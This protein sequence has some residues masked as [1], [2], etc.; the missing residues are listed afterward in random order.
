[1]VIH[2][3][4]AAAPGTA[5]RTAAVVFAGFCAFL[6]LYAPQPLLPLLGQAFHKS[7]AEVSLIVSI[8]TLA[9]ALAAPFAGTV[10]DRWGRKRVIVPATLLL[11]VPTL[12]AATSTS[13]AQLLFWRF[14]Q[15]IFTPAI[16]AVTVAYIN[17]E[18]TEGTGGAVAAYV[19]G[20]VIGGFC[21]RM[22]TALVAAHFSWQWSFISLGVLTA[23]GG[24]AIW[25]W[26]PQ[27]R[28]RAR[29][30]HSATRAIVRHLQNPPLVATY[31]AGFAVLFSLLAIF[32]YVN[33]H[34]AAPPFGLGT[35]ALGFLF[36]VY[37]VGAV[38]TPYAGRWIDRLG[39][40][41]AFSLAMAMAVVGGL[42]TLIPWLPAIVAGLAI[43]CTG[44]F[45]SQSAANAYIGVVAREAK[46]AA[47][48]LYVTFYY[49]GGSFGAAIPGHFWSL[50]GWPA[51]IGL[52]TFVQLATIWIACRYWRDVPRCAEP[53]M[54]EVREEPVSAAVAR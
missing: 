15:G 38:V 35:S 41:A 25:A 27:D 19:T 8:S 48:G 9:V 21:G 23:A 36:V 52:I 16:F 17:D 53:V 33:F 46:A 4:P 32:T 3:L 47:V 45:I 22:L 51:C 40:R 11:A 43:A 1:M 49:L 42:V 18:W 39:H 12:L 30:P 20:T 24:L 28:R 31:A 6:A 37:L 54:L 26:L 10:A 50:G 13:F 7:P 5:R 29:H 44:V 34:L 14:W 2:T